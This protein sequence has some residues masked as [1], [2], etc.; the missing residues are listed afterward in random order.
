MFDPET[1]IWIQPDPIFPRSGLSPY[2][3]DDANSINETDAS[4]LQAHPSGMQNDPRTEGILPHAVMGPD[5]DILEDPR[6]PKGPVPPDELASFQGSFIPD[7]GF[8]SAGMYR[9]PGDARVHV[10]IKFHPKDGVVDNANCTQIKFVQI[11]QSYTAEYKFA[12]WNT[13]F[14]DA[15]DAD[16]GKILYPVETQ[17]WERIPGSYGQ[18]ARMKD[19]PGTDPSWNLKRI[20]FSFKTYAVATK[21]PEAGHSY[22]YIRW[23]AVI[24]FQHNR[25]FIFIDG[26]G[27][28]DEPISSTQ[29]INWETIP[30][31]GN[32]DIGARTA[33]P[34]AGDLSGQKAYW[35]PLG[36]VNR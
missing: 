27:S 34:R 10:A 12:R 22:G 2:V 4:G 31:T 30:G 5:L 6:N 17:P 8:F 3:F 16:P 23:G 20:T 15:I 14:E 28:S 24:D 18:Y 32:I 11:I 25:S 1:K 26:I 13:A 9:Y 36:L 7:R 35:S 21:G 19:D 33:T 29:T